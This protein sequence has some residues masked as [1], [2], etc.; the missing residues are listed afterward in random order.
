MMPNPFMLGTWEHG[1]YEK[2]LTF[3]WAG[4][5]QLIELIELLGQAP[6]GY[7]E[8]FKKE[9]E[10]AYDSGYNQGLAD[11]KSDMKKRLSKAVK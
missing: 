6:P 5:K 3:G 10:R 4:D 11:A 7:I 1:A 9:R 8:T 2:A